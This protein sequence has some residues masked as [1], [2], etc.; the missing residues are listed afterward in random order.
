MP[1]HQIALTLSRARLDAVLFDLDGVV[2]DTARVHAAAW[3]AMFDDYLR[4]H[5]ARKGEDHGPFDADRDY[6]RYV[7]GRP[8]I[9]GVE[10]FLASRGIDLPT[11]DP[12]D[13]PGRE[14]LSGLGNRKNRLFRDALGEQGVHLYG[15]AVTLLQR[16]RASGFRVAVVTA[17]KNCDLILREAGIADLFDARVDGVEAKR[18]SLAGKPAPD[19]FLEAAARLRCGPARTAV[20]EDAIAGV[21]AAHRGHFGLVVGVDR[22]GQPDALANAGADWVVR[23]LCGLGVEAATLEMSSVG[24]PLLTEATGFARLLTARR[25]ALF[26]DYDGTLTPIV[27]RPEDA[28][29]DEPMR[30]AL[31]AAA[32]VMPVAIISGRD[33]EDVR[34]LVGLEGLVYGGNHGF[35]LRGPNLRFELPEA[36]NALEDLEQAEG[37]LRARLAG[38]ADARLERKRFAIAVHYRRVA[39]ADVARVERA[40]AAAADGRPALRRTGGKMIFELRPALDWDKGHAVRWLLSRLGLDR[41]DVLPIYI[42]DDD[43]DEDAFRALAERGGIGVL[44][45]ETPKASLATFR[46]PDAAAVRALLAFLTESERRGRQ[47]QVAES[48]PARGE[49]RLAPMSGEA[50]GRVHGRDER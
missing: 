17:S 45:A 28:K 9:E 42:G 31:G 22:D 11:G 49:T 33:L 12:D 16:L 35:D 36:L 25:P 44:V 21:C 19:T 1:D 10:H 7:D 43:T 3:K 26:L 40:V 27:D 38:V 2:T 24:P 34:A 23:D 41:P 47:K 29:L 4:A 8:R 6:R 13:P 46:I 20:L 15:C 14:T 48:G 5:G 32:A 39:D 18:L 50:Q 30:A 37:E